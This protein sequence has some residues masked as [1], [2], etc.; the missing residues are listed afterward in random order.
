MDAHVVREFTRNS[1]SEDFSP[2]STQ[3]SLG[4]KRSSQSTQEDS[5]QSKKNKE[6]V[7]VEFLDNDLDIQIEGKKVGT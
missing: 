3:S 6:D 2:G 1:L 5:T 4:S 7:I